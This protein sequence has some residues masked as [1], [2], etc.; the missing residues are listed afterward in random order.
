MRQKAYHQ[1]KK[2]RKS[3]EYRMKI[4]EFYERK[5]ISRLATHMKDMLLVMAYDVRG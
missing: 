2:D 3:G 5:E 1:A 4:V